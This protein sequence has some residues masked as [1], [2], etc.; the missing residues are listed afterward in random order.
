M[1]PEQR[2]NELADLAAEVRRLQREYFRTRTPTALNQ[3][4]AAE[5][6][7]DKWL[8]DFFSPVQQSSLFDQNQEQRA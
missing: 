5:N 4:K 7:L 2:L 3:S 1:N 8:A 6:R